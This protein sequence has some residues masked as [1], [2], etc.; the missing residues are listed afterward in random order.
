MTYVGDF[1]PCVH[2][3]VFS[4]GV[5]LCEKCGLIRRGQPSFG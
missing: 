2:K 4:N 3:F 1:P 5:V